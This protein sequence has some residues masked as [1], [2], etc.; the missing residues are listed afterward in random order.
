MNNLDLQ[1]IDSNTFLSPFLDVIRSKETSGSLTCLALNAVNKFLS[2]G[3]I[4][5]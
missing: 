5:I 4:G 3:L 2:Y 1:D